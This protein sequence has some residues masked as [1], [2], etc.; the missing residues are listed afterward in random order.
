MLW[1]LLVAILF[2]TTER[3]FFVSKLFFLAIVAKLRL[4]TL[5]FDVFLWLASFL[6]VDL[7]CIRIETGQTFWTRLK[8]VAFAFAG[9]RLEQLE[10]REILRVH[11]P[12]SLN[13]LNVREFKLLTEQI[14][15]LCNNVIYRLSAATNQSTN[16]Q[17]EQTLQLDTSQ[18]AV[19]QD[20]TV[21]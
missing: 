8:K 10:S 21:C 20:P 19:N 15:C 12:K 14:L 6:W 18:L 5:P 9:K 4:E 13:A 11:R 1:L 17:R 16:D 3:F 2:L 7:L